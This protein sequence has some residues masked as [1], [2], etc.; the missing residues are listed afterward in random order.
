M[1]TGG[2]S[3]GRPRDSGRWQD[4][5]DA[6]TRNVADHGYAG[7]NFSEIAS[8]LGISKGTIVHHFGTKSKMFAQMHDGYM[9]R[10]LAEAEGI[11][12]AFDG[13]ARRLAGLIFAFFEYQEIDRCATIAFQR[14]VPTLATHAELERS[15][16]LRS[17]YL[18][19]VR[20]VISDGIATGVFRNLDVDVQSLLIF[21]ASQWS[22][23]WFRPDERLT[24][25]EA[26]GQLV[27][28]VLG[29]LLVDRL[30][31]DELADPRGQVA[32]TVERI[33]I[34]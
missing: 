19:L 32:A 26:A 9:D 21:G 7:S 27:Q 11:I 14:E 30:T 5:L 17:R 23:T 18:G 29:G 8:E 1:T 33:L 3:N 20:G 31:V 4:I 15:R 10:R 6:F 13:P 12:A 24:A 22:W 34:P 16:E 28:L 25:L 2:S